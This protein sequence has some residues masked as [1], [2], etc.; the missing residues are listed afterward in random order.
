LGW[1]PWISAHIIPSFTTENAV[2]S[3]A[4]LSITRQT[5]TNPSDET[6]HQWQV[7]DPERLR[8]RKG[9][10]NPKNSEHLFDLFVLLKIQEVWP[11]CAL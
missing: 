7:Q 8:Y 3:P 4:G 5:T 9:A 10:L 11:L 1:F 2:P 6:R